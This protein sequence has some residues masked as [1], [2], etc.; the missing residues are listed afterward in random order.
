[1]NPRPSYA[2]QPFVRQ[3]GALRAGELVRAETEEGVFRK[4]VAMAPRVAG[5][6]FFKI[7]TSAE[8]DEWA[9]IEVLCTDGDLPSAG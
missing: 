3:N 5:M 7:T 9:E 4:G 1:M 2:L 6:A 8:G